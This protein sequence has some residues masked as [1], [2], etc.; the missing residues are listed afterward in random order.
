MQLEIENYDDIILEWIPYNQF[1][2]IKETGKNGSITVYSATWKNGPLVNKYLRIFLELYGISQDPNTNDYILIFNWLSGNEKIDDFIQEV[3]L[4][5]NNIIMLEWV[6]YNQFYKIKEISNNGFATIYSAI[7]R[8]GPIVNFYKYSYRRNSNENVFLKQLHNSHN[9]TRFVINEVKKYLTS[10]SSF[11][12]IYGISQNPDTK[13]YIL[14]QNK[15]INLTG[16]EKIDNTIQEIQLKILKYDDL[17]FEWVP[18]SQFDEIKQIGKGG[19]ATIYSA[20]WK[21]GPL[22]RGKNMKE[23]HIKKLH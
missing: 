16:N 11:L 8:K 18:Y 4:K 22:Y 7:W 10:N 2:E 15:P 23:I 14:V 19:F 3:Q 1:N 9:L 21:D 12:V 6:P 13:D 20:I 5:T 17:I